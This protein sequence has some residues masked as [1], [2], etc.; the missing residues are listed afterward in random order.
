[1]STIM[2]PTLLTIPIQITPIVN[3]LFMSTPSL[4]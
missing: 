1:V 2:H 3:V 4:D